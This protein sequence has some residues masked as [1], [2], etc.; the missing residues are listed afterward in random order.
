MEGLKDIDWSVF[1][2]NFWKPEI[3]VNHRVDVVGVSQEMSDFGESDKDKRPVLVLK[4]SKVDNVEYETPVLFTTGSMSLIRE[5]NLILQEHRGIPKI[6]LFMKR[7]SK[8]ETIII[9][10]TVELAHAPTVEEVMSN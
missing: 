1:R 4:L 3:G 9:D 7:I 8:R 5:L 6:R 10:R 2:S